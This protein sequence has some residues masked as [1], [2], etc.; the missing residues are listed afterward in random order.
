MSLK[1]QDLLR[2]ANLIGGTWTTAD[3]GASFAVINPATGDPLGDVPLCGAAETHRAIAAANAA[4]PAWRAL[5]AR[6]RAQILQA[7]NRL[8]VDNADDL[9]QIITAECGKPLAEMT[10]IRFSKIQ[11]TAQMTLCVVLFLN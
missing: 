4:W 6:R 1:N 8:I 10:V 9:A 3:D 11:I 2:A 7:W 5:T